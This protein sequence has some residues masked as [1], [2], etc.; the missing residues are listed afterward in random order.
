ML[1]ESKDFIKVDTMTLARVKWK[2]T[3]NDSLVS[4]K[5]SAFT[6]WLKKALKTDKIKVVRE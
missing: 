5:E 2:S 3:L 4:V 1:L 6:T